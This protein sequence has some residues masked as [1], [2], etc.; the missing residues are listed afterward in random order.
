[1]SYDAVLL[2]QLRVILPEG[3]VVPALDP[4]LYTIRFVSIPVH[5]ISMSLG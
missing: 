2:T 4:V 5:F 1:M 3:T